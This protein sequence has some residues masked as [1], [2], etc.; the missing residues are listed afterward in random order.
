VRMEKIAN[1]VYT[2]MSLLQQQAHPSPL[3]GILLKSRA[4]LHMIRAFVKRLG[5]HHV[6]VS[7]A[8]FV[9]YRRENALLRRRLP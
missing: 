7:A 8:L 3:Q 4:L 5:F 9:Y 2:E 1:E 6:H